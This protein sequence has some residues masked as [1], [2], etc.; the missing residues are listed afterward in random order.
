MVRKALVYSVIFGP[1][2]WIM[3]YILDDVSL[4]DRK[5]KG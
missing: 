2:V 1:K 3:E 4:E 5:E